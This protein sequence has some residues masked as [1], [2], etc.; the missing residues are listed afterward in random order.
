[1]IEQRAEASALA[2]P[3]AFSFL[4]VSTG[5]LTVVNLKTMIIDQKFLQTLNP[6]CPIRKKKT[7]E[8]FFLLGN[9]FEGNTYLLKNLSLFAYCFC[10]FLIMSNDKRKAFKSNYLTCLHD[11]LLASVKSKIKI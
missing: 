8:V 6:A 4:G 5:F 3:L 2:L 11:V 1:M 9:L 7:H 10:Y